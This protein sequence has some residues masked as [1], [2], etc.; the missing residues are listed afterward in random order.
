M[1]L[2]TGRPST[3]RA[4]WLA[5]RPPT[6]WAAVAPIAV[7]TACASAL[8]GFRPLTALAALVGA[9]F[10]QVGTNFANDLFDFR[11]GADGSDRIGPTRAV[12][13]GWL[14]E[15][16]MWAGTW[17]AFGVAA[18]AGLYLSW[19]AGFPVLVIGLLSIGAGLAYTGGPYPLAYHGLGDLFVFAFFG[20]VA[21]AGTTWV[22]LLSLP[23][24]A[25]W[26]SVPVGALATAILVVNNLRDIESDRR[27]GKRTLAV[28]LG[29]A[30]TRAEYAS[31]LA[32]AFAV[33]LAILGLGLAGFSVL[34][35]L[36]LLPWAIQLLG[37]V[38]RTRGA[39]LNP[40]LGA[41]ARLLLL[42]S[43]LFS[44]GLWLS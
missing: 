2:S 11:K 14:D 22:Q 25:L 44:L 4:W 33:P 16:Q 8:G 13:A 23:A 18:V 20:F 24:L 5:A 40:F 30:A 43:V 3:A 34:L 21:V 7:G 32:L 38:R 29:A 12:Q 19:V 15:A 10:I 37:G 31:L 35:P 17:A 41:T 39:A 6:L 36:V 42:F 1:R 28:R 9:I 27:A 26:A